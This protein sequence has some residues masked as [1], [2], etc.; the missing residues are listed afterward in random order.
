MTM[1][2][3]MNR[4]ACAAIA[5]SLGFALAGCDT[6]AEMNRSLNSV[7][8]PVIS[9][10]TFAL[11]LS[12]D[13]SGLSVPEQRRL[14][15]WFQTMNVG[16]GDRIA[17]DDANGNFEARDDVARIAG[18]HGLLLSD[19][20]PITNGAVQPGTVRV[21][22]TRSRAEVPNCPDWSTHLAD[23]GTN[24]T[25]SGYGCAVN[26][27]LAAMVADPEHLIHGANGTGDTVIMS[28]TK[29]IETYREQKP[30]GAN[31]LPAVSSQEG[32]K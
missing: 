21:V 31:G 5:L 2:I 16:Y 13:S 19:G 26:G 23:Y 3:R 15:E 12:A 7:K 14:A 24:T 28:S 27:N 1:P 8:Q 10:E 9:R 25:S 4:T 17:V 18:R 22:I 30:T 29:A 32:T 11:D 6:T 20:A